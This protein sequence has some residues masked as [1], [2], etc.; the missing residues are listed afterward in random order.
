MLYARPLDEAGSLGGAA[1]AATH[2]AT[3]VGALRPTCN[4]SHA[5]LKQ[6]EKEWIKREKRKGERER[7]REKWEVSVTFL[8]TRLG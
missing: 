6:G 5:Q 8:S 3:Y 4:N 1:A 2:Q 7:E